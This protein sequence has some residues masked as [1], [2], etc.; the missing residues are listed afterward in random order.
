MSDEPALPGL[1]EMKE[2]HSLEPM[3]KEQPKPRFEFVNRA[4]LVFRTIDVEQLIDPDHPA[5]AIWQFLGRVDLSGFSVGV[6]AYEGERGR[7][8][9]D[10]RLLVSLWVYSYSRGITA[11]R[12]IARLCEYDPA[13]QWLTGMKVVN[14]HSLTDFRV[15]HEAALRQLFIQILAVLSQAGLVSL[16][17]VMNDGTKIKAQASKQSLQG[18]ERLKEH[19][20]VARRHVAAL[21]REAAETEMSG[22]LA[23]AKERVARESQQRLEAALAEFAQLQKKKPQTDE[24]KLRVSKSEPEARKMKQPDGGYALSYNVQLSTEQSHG[25]IVGVGLSQSATDCNELE[26][27]VERVQQNTGQLPTQVVTDGGYLTGKNIKQ[28]QELGIDFITP[29][30]DSREQLKQRGID[31]QFGREAFNYDEV[32]NCYQCPAGQTL[33]FKGKE[34]RGSKTRYRYQAQADI[35]ATCV[36]KPQC[37]PKTARGRSLA[38]LEY[39]AE[40]AAHIAKMQ[41]AA[42]QEIYKQ[43]GPTAE[44]PIAWIKEKLRLRRFH[45]RGLLKAELEALWA[46]ATYNIQQWMRWCW[47]PQ[48]AS[49]Q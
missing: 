15:K 34:R 31:P 48:F 26:A 33:S 18:K 39:D 36:W 17:R 37:C 9:Y 16:E 8:A 24:K 25:L 32:K 23:K 20:E 5:R 12:E 19:L 1:E 27:A 45:V 42:A 49:D 2:R 3:E 4:Q 40:V 46:A 7:A 30:T 41:T 43:R 10:P 28:M 35:C 6:Q 14:Y 13:Y 38:R 29:V 44:F 47:T 11:G 22:R 21:E